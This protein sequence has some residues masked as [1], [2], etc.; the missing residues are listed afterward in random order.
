[1]SNQLPFHGIHV[2]VLQLLHSLLVAPDVE[3]MK[4]QLPEARQLFPGTLERQRH[5]RRGCATLAA[6]LV[7]HALL[8]HLQDG[9]GRAARRFADQQMDVLGHD[10]VPHQSEAVPLAHLSE[11]AHE[12]VTRA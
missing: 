11:N 1:M 9:R 4:T 3:A 8:E 6:H 2:H 12:G 5:L 10:D 7:R